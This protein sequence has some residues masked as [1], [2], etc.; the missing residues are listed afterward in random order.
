[1]LHTSGIF[2]ELRSTGGI[3][4]SQGGTW[5]WGRN[6]KPS[7]SGSTSARAITGTSWASKWTA[8]LKRSARS[9]CIIRRI[10]SLLGL[11]MGALASIVNRSVVAHLGSRA[12]TA[13]L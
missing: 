8:S 3:T 2:G 13:S 9:D 7:L 5:E 11:A 10:W 12:K 4:A 1:G 6:R